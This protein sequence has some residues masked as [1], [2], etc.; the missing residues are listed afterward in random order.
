MST[1]AS[2]EATVLVMA[3]LAAGCRDG[4]GIVT[5]VEA[6]SSG[7]VRLR[8][9]RLYAALDRLRADGLVTIERQ[10]IGRDRVRRYYRLMSPAARRPIEPDCVPAA[11]LRLR[12]GDADRDATAAALCEHYALGRLTVDELRVR[13]GVAL[14]ARTRGEISR[15]T[16]DLPPLAAALVPSDPAPGRR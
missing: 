12:V 11:G 4:S 1:R 14:A 7:R 10:D 16:W 6:I 9:G 5:D 2:H 15:S 3:V 8:A 13:L